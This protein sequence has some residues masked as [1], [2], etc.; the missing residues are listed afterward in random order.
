MGH[1]SGKTTRRYGRGHDLAKYDAVVQRIVVKGVDMKALAPVIRL[2]LADA[3]NA[4]SI[5][6]AKT[7]H[8]I[9]P[10]AA[11]AA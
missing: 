9:A 4:G 2:A 3:G 11:I 8:K 5:V 1:S 7:P 6:A 10:T